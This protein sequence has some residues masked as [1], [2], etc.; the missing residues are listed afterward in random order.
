MRDVGANGT[1]WRSRATRDEEQ[2]SLV[3]FRERVVTHTGSGW[4]G[5]CKRRIPCGGGR[6]CPTE[7]IKSQ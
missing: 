7:P 5:G 3:S 2:V 6:H 1:E 4:V